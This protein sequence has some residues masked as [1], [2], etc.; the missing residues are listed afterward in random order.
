MR[1]SNARM[2]P[3]PLLSARI[4]TSRYFT[5]ITSSSDQNIRD[6]TPSMSAGVTATGLAP[7]KQSRTAYRGLV[8]ISP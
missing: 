3:S 4:T 7:K 8:P 1:R 5:E 2:P 6:S